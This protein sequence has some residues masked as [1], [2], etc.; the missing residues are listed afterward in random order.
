MKVEFIGLD[1]LSKRQGHKDF[2][3]H[4]VTETDFEL[5]FLKALLKSNYNKGIVCHPK[6]TLL[7]LDG[8]ISIMITREDEPNEPT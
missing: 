5:S 8:K 3:I 4:L 1:E 6:A 7:A 2:A